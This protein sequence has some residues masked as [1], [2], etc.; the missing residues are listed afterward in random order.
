[1]PC[2]TN[3]N[4]QS[5]LQPNG[6]D[7]A[8]TPPLPFPP[9][10]PSPTT[11]D[12]DG[13][14]QASTAALFGRLNMNQTYT[15][16]FPPLQVPQA[17]RSAFNFTDPNVITQYQNALLERI[18]MCQ[19]VYKRFQAATGATDPTAKRCLAQLAVNIV[20]FCQYMP[21]FKSGNP[22]DGNFV[23]DDI[24]TCF[25]YEPGK[26]VY[27]TVL[28]RLVI[29]EAYVE[30]A[31]PNQNQNQQPVNFWV[32]LHNTYVTHNRRQT[33][34]PEQYAHVH[35]TI[36]HSE[37]GIARLWVD[38][39]PGTGY[40]AYRLILADATFTSNNVPT[41][42]ATAIGDP[43]NPEGTPPQ[44]S[45][46]KIIAD[47]KPAQT[48]PNQPL[49]LSG[50]ELNIIRTI[51]SPDTGY[52]PSTP[53]PPPAQG[54]NPNYVDKQAP[55]EVP[56]LNS[57]W[58][59]N[60]GWYVLGPPTVFPG[61]DY[62]P[63]DPKDP[64]N[65]PPR[66]AKF[67]A[68]LPH[69][70]MTIDNGQAGQK[71]TIVLQ[72][73]ACPYLPPQELSDAGSIQQKGYF[74]PYVTVDYMDQVQA[75]DGNLPV[76]QRKSVGR[77]QPFAAHKDSQVPQTTPTALQTIQPSQP[78]H[79]FFYRNS[80]KDGSPDPV[81]AFD[82]VF[83]CNRMLLNTLELLNVSGYKP[84]E[85]TQ[86]FMIGKPDPNT[87]KPALAGRFGYRAP[88]YETDKL[89]YRGLEFMEGYLRNQWTPPGG[90]DAGRVNINTVW[91]YEIFQGLC[92]H[93]GGHW[94]TDVGVQSIFNR[95]MMS[96]TPNGIPAAG[97]RPFFSYAAPYTAP[98][99][100]FPQG[101]SVEDTILRQAPDLDPQ[102]LVDPRTGQ[103]IPTQLRRRLFEP[104][105]INAQNPNPPELRRYACKEGGQDPTEPPNLFF[106]EQLLRRIGD[107][108]TTR[109][110]VF[111]VWLTVGFFEVLDDSNPNLPP[112]L[113]KEI[114]ST[115]G[116]QKRYRM[117]AIID[118]TRLT[119]ATDPVSGQPIPGQAGP[120]PYFIDSLNSV[121]GSGAEE[122]VKVA[123][124][125]G[126]YEELSW[127]IQAG[128]QLIVDTGSNREAITV[129]RTALGDPYGDYFY[130]V[131]R[132]PHAVGFCVRNAMPGNPGPQPRFDMR[133]PNYQSVVRWFSIVEGR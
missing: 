35:P 63:G 38:Y 72:R 83:W 111:V 105:Y 1:M 70:N 12:F 85:L 94:F 4:G 22:Y 54:A 98:G 115:E 24:M 43:N 13:N 6:I 127:K 10:G 77:N 97:D 17:T 23:P 36:P 33:N 66:Y 86:R 116:R 64:N 102:E 60:R 69:Q 128:D 123:V 74:N 21:A 103:P 48:P 71:Y 118:R 108:I 15:N 129:T 122:R 76:Q 40:A 37:D 65:K 31:K 14:W 59:R 7:F 131:F 5:T 117:F 81:F 126:K 100:Q 52:D 124:L 73:L 47:Y 96:R 34:N 16:E 104:K 121:T 95:M 101:L 51:G 99:A 45:I 27:G 125:S 82:Y 58:G 41:S 2:Y 11:G 56:Y 90:R 57:S 75:N 109:S 25:Q 130:A 113:G 89:I 84:S 61:T 88:F 107:H 133:H 9:P 42:T 119:V 28:P 92:D 112:V 39:P 26:W 18:Y 53:P 55:K 32:E 3:P 110:N 106:W 93:H 120:R 29:N 87:G 8:A 79:T 44:Q 114:G 67:F 78:S 91:D 50:D 68:T 20:D 132:Q 62:D 80:Q 46:K 49:V 30:A 19:E